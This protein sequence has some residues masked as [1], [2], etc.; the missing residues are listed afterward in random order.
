MKKVNQNQKKYCN[1][2]VDYHLLGF[3]IC[4]GLYFFAWFVPDLIRSS[5]QPAPG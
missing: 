2:Y 3:L 5:W 4:S 1:K